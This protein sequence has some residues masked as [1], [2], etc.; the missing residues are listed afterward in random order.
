[1]RRPLVLVFIAILAVAVGI[2]PAIASLFADLW[3]FR[4]V[5]ASVVFESS[6]LLRW[7]MFLGV[8]VVVFAFIKTNIRIASRGVAVAKILVVDPNRPHVDLSHL[9]S[10]F[11]SPLAFVVAFLAALSSASGWLAVVRYV[12]QVPFHLTDPVFGRDI[13][14]YVFTLPVL[15]GVLTLIRT[16]LVVSAIACIV[17]YWTRDEVRIARRRFIVDPAA[18]LHLGALIGTWFIVTALTLWF[19]EIPSLLYSTTG[20]LFGASYTDLH[21]TLPALRLLAIVAACAGLVVFAMARKRLA[22]TTIGAFAVYL[23]VAGIGTWL[24]PQLLQKLIVAPNEV[25]RETP[26]LRSHI[27][28]TRQAWGID[29]VQERELNGEASL[30]AQ[31]LHANAVTVDN[32]RLW[33][34]APLLQTFGALQEIR[35]Y[36]D[37]VSL[38]DDRYM[39]DGHYRQILLSPRELN[40]ASLPTQTFINTHLTFTHGMG[41]TAAPVNQVTDEGLPT[42]LVKDLPPATTTASLRITKPQ[43]YY[44]E[45]SNEFVIV[46]TAQ[47]EF[48]YPS[49]DVNIFTHYAGIGGVPISSLFAR[50]VMAIEFG[51]LNILLSDDIKPQ[52]RILYNRAVLARAEKAL[53]FLTFDRDPY[54][55]IDHAGALYWI[56]DAY[57]ESSEYPYSLPAADGTNYMRNSVKVV[58]SAYD[59][60][61]RAYIMD[62]KDPLIQTYARA[63]PGL[64]LPI[65]AMP[66]DLRAH[67]RYPTDLFRIQTALYTTY[68]MNDPQGFYLREDQWQIP[69]QT[70][71]SSPNEPFMRHMIMR[72]PDEQNAEYLYMA[73]FTPRGKD[74]LAAWMVARNDGTEYGQL[75]VYRFPKNSLVYGPG[76][77]VSRINQDTDISRQLT[78]WDQRGSKVIRGELLVIPIEKALLYVQPL[79]LSS[80]EGQIP[81]LKRVVV[82]YQNHVVMAETL[83]GALSGLFG[84]AA[85]GSPNTAAPKTSGAPNAPLSSQPLSDGVSVLAREA[86]EHYDRAVAAQRNGDWAT[87]GT[88]LQQLGDVLKRM[89]T[90]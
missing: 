65:A 18:A 52:S 5:G 62:T 74:N 58:I 16:V 54:I 83:E 42:L 27:R 70:E 68:H 71:G 11:A 47:R 79:Y 12:H 15:D 72:L 37:F 61:M 4:E 87:Y 21:A 9:P 90:R 78:L 1:M 53:P 77:I 41:V 80:E 38:D 33:D 45:T 25:T 3:W 34:R 49:G 32:I 82:A 51:S 56:L 84:D 89:E 66:A 20:P 8:G 85:E 46:N 24:Y 75:R 7:G 35:T 14:Y 76:Q 28:A 59:G 63:F 6:L 81:E 50:L 86:R 69:E 36:Y 10:R 57:T 40:P 73:P 39:V 19:V 30:S 55:V 31:D 48:D 67:V 88:E 44:G 13:A 64:F 2:L 43:L 60:T 26:Q 17:T 22:M 23:L 29:S